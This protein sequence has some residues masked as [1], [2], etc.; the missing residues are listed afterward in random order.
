MNSGN[1]KLKN[2]SHSVG[3]NS[4]HLVLTPHARFPVFGFPD[5]RY[6]AIKAIDWICERHSIE[7]I[8][9]EVM[10]DHVHL[11]ITCPPHYSVRRLAGIIKGGIS[12]YIRKRRPQLKKYST[13]WGKGYMYRSVGCVS[14]ETIQRY[15]E[16]SNKWSKETQRT[17]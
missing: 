6:L 8:A 9:K 2:F 4:Y 5:Q 15:I 7:L 13:L 11:F 14:A 10:S 16:E 17:L 3:Q 12:Y 1:S